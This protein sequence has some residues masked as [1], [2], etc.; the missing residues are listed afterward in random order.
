VVAPPWSA[1]RSARSALGDRRRPHRHRRRGRR[2]GTRGPRRHAPAHMSRVWTTIVL[3]GAGTFAMR[4]SFLAA[5]HRWRRCRR[6]SSACSARSRQP[7]WRRSSACAA[8]T[9]G[10][11]RSHA[12]AVRR[13][14]DRRRG[15]WR[16]RN[17]ALTLVVGMT[18]L[19]LLE[20]L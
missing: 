3:A 8:P 13:R 1:P 16:T 15:A 12:P 20:A 10:R 11:R 9:R 19:V 4:A 18:T 17:T 7:H 2:R 6:A 5:A 14:G